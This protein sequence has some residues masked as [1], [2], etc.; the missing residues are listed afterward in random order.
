MFDEW[1]RGRLAERGMIQ[2]QLAAFARVSPSAVSAWA[3]GKSVPRPEQCVAIA[4]VL[5]VPLEEVLAAAGYPVAASEGA[6]SPPLPPKL[7]SL[8]PVLLMLEEDEL[9]VVRHTALGLLEL[10]EVRGQHRGHQSP[11]PGSEP[12]SAPAP[13]EKRSRRR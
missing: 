2:S 9:T 10:R 8:I 6:P 7:A 12:A 3:R 1:L 13:R 4:R 5:H 11:A